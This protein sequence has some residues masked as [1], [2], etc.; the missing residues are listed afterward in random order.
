MVIC[1]GRICN[2][3]LVSESILCVCVQAMKMG[4]M[5]DSSQPVLIITVSMD[6][7]A[8]ICDLEICSGLT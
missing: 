5:L 2:E 8:G 3:S 6:L 7:L 4:F 1:D